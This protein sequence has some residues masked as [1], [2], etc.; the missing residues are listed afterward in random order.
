[1]ALVDRNP[2]EFEFSIPVLIVGAGACGMSAAIAARQAGADVLVLERDAVPLGTT[3]M[4][5]GLIPAANTKAQRRAGIVNDTS[6]IFAS[7]LAKKVGEEADRDRLAYV[8]EQSTLTVDWLIEDLALP[9]T[10]FD[11]GSALPGH[12][13]ARLH[14]TVNRTGEELLA[15]LVSK[16]GE[17]GVDI[18]ADAR[19]TVLY[20]DSENRVGGIAIERPDGSHELIGCDTII[21]ASCGY[22][23]NREIVE[24]CIPEIGNAILHTHPGAQGDALIWGQQLGAKTGDLSAYQGHAS[25]AAGQGL[26]VSYISIGEGGFQVNCEGERFSN[27]ALGYS[28]QAVHVA[29]QPDGFAWQIFDN[30]IS[31]IMQEII[32]YRDVVSAGALRIADTIEDLAKQISVPTERLS[33]EIEAINSTAADGVAD[34]FGRTFDPAQKL[35]APF[36]A[37]K[38]NGALFH[39]Q[40][41]LEVDRNAQVISEDGGTLPNLFAGGG[42]ARGISGSGA[43]GYVAGNGLMT[44][45]TYGRLAGRAAAALAAQLATQP[46]EKAG[47]S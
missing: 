2:P 6:N 41:G 4:S 33:G 42:A 21:L 1:M 37:V 46:L 28:E 34:R 36:V 44:A 32:E 16:A 8:C 26:L 18:M 14:G 11:A 7:D 29:A 23:A 47:A 43:S 5:S 31:E 25:L 19:V 39:T 13:R 9:L 22:A 15:C 24:K 35:Q 38:V 20:A 3:S 17:L 30:R 10:L 40:G 12:S 45:T 27:E